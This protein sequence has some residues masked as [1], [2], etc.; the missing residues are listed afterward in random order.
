MISTTGG[1]NFRKLQPNESSTNSIT[2]M[3]LKT[4]ET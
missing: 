2:E 1:L 4:S 3:P